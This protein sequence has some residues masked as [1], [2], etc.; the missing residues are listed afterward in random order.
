MLFACL[1]RKL[2]EAAQLPRGLDTACDSTGSQYGVAQAKQRLRFARMARSRAGFRSSAGVCV[3]SRHHIEHPG[4]KKA[5]L[6]QI[7]QRLRSAKCPLLFMLQPCLSLLGWQLGRGDPVPAIDRARHPLVEQ[8]PL[9]TAL[10]GCHKP[11]KADS[12]AHRTLL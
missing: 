3:C 4:H 2:H 7:K 9:S 8:W 6:K 12:R 5:F 10:L 11:A 1:L